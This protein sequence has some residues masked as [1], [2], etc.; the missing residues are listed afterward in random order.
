MKAKK[1]YEK[2]VLNGVDM[3]EA[4]T[5]GCCRQANKVCGKSPVR[6]AKGAAAKSS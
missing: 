4:H 3:L 1:K 5:G 2:P 6:A